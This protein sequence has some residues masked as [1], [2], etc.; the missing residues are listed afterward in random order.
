[1]H[2]VAGSRRH[3]DRERSNRGNDR[4]GR[5]WRELGFRATAS[6]GSQR[7]RRGRERVSAA[8]EAPAVVEVTSP[9]APPAGAAVGA[10]VEEVAVQ[11]AAPVQLEERADAG[12]GITTAI[13]GSLP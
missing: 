10:T 9:V 11:S 2:V 7:G 3:D 12:G 5:G 4:A 1:M 8:A 13:V 6:R